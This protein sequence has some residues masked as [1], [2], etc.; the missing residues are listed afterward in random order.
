VPQSLR[1]FILRAY[2]FKAIADY[3]TMPPPRISTARAT[4]AVESAEQ[5]LEAVGAL[6]LA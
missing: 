1:D 2:D 3:A 5:F 6:L 4:T